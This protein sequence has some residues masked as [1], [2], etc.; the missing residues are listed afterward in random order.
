[1]LKKVIY[2]LVI[3]VTI[4]LTTNV[5]YLHTY[6]GTTTEGIKD[7]IIDPGYYNPDTSSSAT[8]ADRVKNFANMV[9]GVIQVVGTIASVAVLIVLGI[10]YMIGGVEERAEY[11]KTMLPY[12]IGALLLFGITNL[13]EIIIK[14]VDVII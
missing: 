13:L 7:G 4:S 10:K 3:I 14:I 5:E 6:A 12:V 8:G 11:K 2:A 1:M 9:I